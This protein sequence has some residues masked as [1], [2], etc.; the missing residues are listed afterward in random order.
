MLLLIPIFFFLEN[1]FRSLKPFSTFSF[2]LSAL[3]IY[4]AYLIIFK[5]FIT[6]TCVLVCE[7]MCEHVW[8]DLVCRGQ[9]A[10][11][12]FFLFSGGGTHYTNIHMAVR[13]LYGVLSLLPLWRGF[14]ESNTAHQAYIMAASTFTHW[15]TLPTLILCY[16]MKKQIYPDFPHPP[17]RSS[18]ISVL[19][20]PYHGNSSLQR[21]ETTTENPSQLIWRVVE[22]SPNEDICKTL[23]HLRFRN[24]KEGRKKSL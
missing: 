10:T 6:F 7:H 17:P 16:D 13:R 11:T 24:V 4:I 23:P 19:F 15:A 20:T 9:R 1:Y 21:M 2:D 8:R 12:F 14:Q 3:Y 22:A 5:M 18:L